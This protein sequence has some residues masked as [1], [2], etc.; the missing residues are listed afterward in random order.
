MSPP[1]DYRAETDHQVIALMSGTSADGVD[2]VLVRISGQA[3]ELSVELLQHEHL[4]YPEELRATVLRACLPDCPVAE[5]TRLNVELGE[6][7]ARAAVAVARTHGTPL[8]RVDLIA[9]HGQ[10]V[11]HLPQ[12]G[13]GGATLQIGEPAVIAERA[14]VTVVADFR[15][16]DMAAGGQGAPLVPYADWVLFRDPKLTRAIQNLGGI[17]NVT[18]VPAGAGIDD[19]IAFDTGPGNMV[20]D[21]VVA[22]LTAGSE[23]CDRD[24]VRAARGRVNDELLA[25]LMQH[26][27][28]QRQPPKSTGREEFGEQF[29]AQV[30][31]NGRGLGVGDNDLVTTVTAFTA[32]TIAAAYRQL[33]PQQPPID[34]VVLGGGGSL[35]PTLCRML[36][37]RLPGSKLMKHE[38]FGIPAQAKEPL[39]FAI[40]GHETM[41][42][43]PANVPRATG[44]RH[45]VILG[46][47]VLPSP[48]V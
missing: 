31:A 40:L 35:N 45:P 48:K 3:P 27:Y 36:A 8:E 13:G 28:L 14:G 16:A 9:S 4:D 11:C 18:Y 23:S 47:I 17:G 10:T 25:W 30:M 1:T 42:G 37:E 46:K 41:M 38:D 24:G 34:E 26:P 20:M 43:R 44:A 19:V 5:I 12:P 2:A 15:P 7:F 39:A 21:G 22:A 32:E 29:V 33:L 6:H